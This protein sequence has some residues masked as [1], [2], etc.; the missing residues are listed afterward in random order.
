MVRLRSSQ[1]SV[2]MAP[3]LVVVIMLGLFLMLVTAACG[4][5]SSSGQTAILDGQVVL[6]PSKPACSNT[7]SCSTP[8][9][10]YKVTVKA[11]DGHV[12]ATATTDQQGHF[13]VTVVPGS[14][15]VQVDLTSGHTGQ[16]QTTPGKVTLVAGQTTHVTITVDS[17]IR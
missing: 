3:R 12:V 8:L 14:Y 13:T 17:G 7:E 10:N 15:V 6:Y 5:G 2:A 9:A 4:A 11:D 16:R 1:R